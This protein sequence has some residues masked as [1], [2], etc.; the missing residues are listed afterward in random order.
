MTRL[1]HMLS[2]LSVVLPIFAFIL[3]GWLTR[4]IGVVGP[5]PQ[6]SL[7]HVWMPPVVQGGFERSEHVIGCEHV[8]GLTMRR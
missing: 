6:G 8:S 1:P 4:R 7:R 2:T 5:P 3:A